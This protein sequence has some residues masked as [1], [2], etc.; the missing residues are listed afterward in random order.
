[1]CLGKDNFSQ[2]YVRNMKTGGSNPSILPEISISIVKIIQPKHFH[3]SNRYLVG[4]RYMLNGLNS[5][6]IQIFLSYT[7]AGKNIEPVMIKLFELA[8]PNRWK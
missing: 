2:L 6:L 7:V 4:L 3:N 8:S 5:S 1:M